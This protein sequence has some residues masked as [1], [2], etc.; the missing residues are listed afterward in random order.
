MSKH[1]QYKWRLYADNNIEKEII[2]H[3]RDEAEMDVLS[4]RDDPALWREQDDSFHYQ[5]ARELKRYLLTHDQDFWDDHQY[6][7]R[8]CPGLVLLPKNDESMAKYFPQLLRTLVDDYNTLREPL[9]LDGVKIQLT[10]E[11]ITIKMMG[12]DTQQ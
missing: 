8:T 3:L 12:R 1:K 9:Y 6:P 2:D 7:L 5:K 11:G 10:W 4:V